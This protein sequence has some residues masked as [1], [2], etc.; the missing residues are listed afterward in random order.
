MNILTKEFDFEIASWY[1]KKIL[2]QTVITKRSITEKSL[3]SS[4]FIFLVVD[5]Y[6]SFMEIKNVIKYLLSLNYQ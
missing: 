4:F 6:I 3:N 5:N 2:H 1:Y